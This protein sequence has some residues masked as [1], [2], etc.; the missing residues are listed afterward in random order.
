VALVSG[1]IAVF[2]ANV[3]ALLP[4]ETLSRLHLTR[5]EGASIAQMRISV[6]ELDDAVI[7]LRRQN[8]QLTSRLTQF[9]QGGTDSLRRIA[10]LEVSV[11]RLLES[12]PVGPSIDSSLPTAS[13]GASDSDL[14]AVDGGQMRVTQQPLVLG[15]LPPPVLSPSSVLTDQPLPPLLQAATPSASPL[16]GERYGIAIGP[17]VPSEDAAATWDDLTVKL[18]SLLL[19]LEPLVS[20]PAGGDGVRLVVGPTET[21]EDASLLCDRLEPVGITCE[22]VPYRGESL[23]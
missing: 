2:S 20:T 4:A 5:F 1:A 18:G 10:A 7:Q 3:S 6:A 21:V 16:A 23:Q 11:P 8:G 12:M 22:A 15:D 9:E 19:G 17:A 13:I 14:I